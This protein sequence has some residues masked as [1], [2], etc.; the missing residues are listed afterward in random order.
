MISNPFVEETM[1]E[2]T[3]IIGGCRSGKSR[4][5]LAL[6]E[7]VP[8]DRKLFVATCVPADAEMRD[9][10]TRHPAQREHRWTTAEVA[11]DIAAT[12]R[13]NSSASDVIVVDCLTLWTSNLMMASKDPE[14]ISQ[15]V[16]QLIA[17]VTQSRCPVILV[18]NEVGLGIV[19]EN[20]LARRF[21]DQAGFINQ[22]VAAA[23]D[24]V[25][26]MVA[27]IAVTIKSVRS[28]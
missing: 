25:V 1:A 10:V 8:G 17:A 5:A 2:S 16:Y 15:Q 20:Q 6:A 19:P 13:D 9:R 28:R 3:L 18:A 4:H 21:R 22:Q 23:V 27:G 24:D 14:A 12:I 26:W 7:A 11:V